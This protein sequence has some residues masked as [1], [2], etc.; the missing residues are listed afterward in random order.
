MNKPYYILGDFNLDLLKYESHKKTSQI[1]DLLFSNS[2]IPV[3]NHPTRITHSTATLIDHIYTNNYN[4]NDKLYQGILLTDI[5]DHCIV[6][7]IWKKST[8]CTANDELVTF[9]QVNEKNL[10]KYKSNLA[11][12]NWT[13]IFEENSCQA[14]FTKF[15]NM[16]NTIFNQS[17][18]LKKIKPKY[19]NKI[20]WISDE[21]K[22]KIKVKNNLYKTYLRHPTCSN[23]SKYKNA[24][25]M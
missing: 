20:P 11:T 22:V 16:H 21:L 8:T 12:W 3:T 19:R 18:P 24:N 25:I 15:F 13:K 9:R 5:S 10:T 1:L 14:A 7:H 2:F 23:F 4:V 17:F 6:F